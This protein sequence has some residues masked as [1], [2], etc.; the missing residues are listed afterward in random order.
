MKWFFSLL[1]L[2]YTLLGSS[3][4]ILKI[5]ENFKS[6]SALSDMQYLE[7]NTTDVSTVYTEPF[8]SFDKQNL[9]YFGK[10]TIWTKLS[11]TNT[12][13][14]PINLIAYNPKAGMDIV[15][16]MRLAV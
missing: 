1:L 7:T 13:D 9:G 12:S 10:A 3:T 5:N 8:Y 11:I 16:M 6:K 14:T 4:L 15:V 2:T